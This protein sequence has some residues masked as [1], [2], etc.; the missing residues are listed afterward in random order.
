M[1]KYDDHLAWLVRQELG[2][3]AERLGFQAATCFD[4]CP[5]YSKDEYETM[6]YETG[7]ENGRAILRL[8][9][10]VKP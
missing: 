4:R 10:M 5:P 8:G 1:T 6:R 7:Y 9:G 3:R 2:A